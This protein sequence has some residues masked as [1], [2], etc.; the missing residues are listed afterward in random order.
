[1]KNDKVACDLPLGGA[2]AMTSSRQKML[3]AVLL[4]GLF[5]AALFS[6]A[7]LSWP[8]I[9][10]IGA[11]A[12]D[13]IIKLL[14]GRS[15]GERGEATLSKTKQAKPLA[16]ALSQTPAEPQER[17]LGK[18]FEPESEIATP[19]ELLAAQFPARPFAGEA[20]DFA[21]L[22]QLAALAGLGGG[23]IPGMPVFV[24][25]GGGGGVTIPP[26]GI[27]Q[28]PAVPEPGTWS[29]MLLGTFLCAAALRRSRRPQ[30]GK[31]VL[32]CAPGT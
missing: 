31:R 29:M 3:V 2:P 21:E 32:R 26:A 27:T 20:P 14:E 1:M 7:A 6:A 12:A 30:P 24:G 9:K 18:I 28:P 15:P 13:D 19:E 11:Q 4:A 16:T 10:P 22:P 5:L 8:Q 23:A 25:G 17:V